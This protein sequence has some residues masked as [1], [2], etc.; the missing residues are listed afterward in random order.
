MDDEPFY[1]VA[2]VGWVYDGPPK[3]R[4]DAKLF[5]V[6]E[7]GFLRAAPKYFPQTVLTIKIAAG[8]DVDLT[9]NDYRYDDRSGK[10]RYTLEQGKGEIAEKDLEA[11]VVSVNRWGSG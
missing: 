9:V 1:V 3:I 5:V 8:M 11:I 2:N 10:Y 6:D 7:Y 4:D